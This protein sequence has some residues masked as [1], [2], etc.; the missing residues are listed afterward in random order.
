MY[1]YRPE[2]GLGRS[3]AAGA[4]ARKAVRPEH[5]LADGHHQARGGA[6]NCV[7]T[8]V[9]GGCCPGAARAPTAGAEDLRAADA[10]CRRG[11]ENVQ[12][13]HQPKAVSVAGWA[14][15][16]RAR[17]ASLPLAVLLRCSLHGGPPARGRGKPSEAFAALSGKAWGAC[18]APNRRSFARRLRGLWEWPRPSVKAARVLEQV[19]KLY[20]R[21]KESGLACRRP[22][23]RRASNML[24]RLRRP[25]NRPVQGGHHRHGS[26]QACEQHGRAWALRR[27]CRTPFGPGTRR[28][29]G[30][31]G[32]GGAR[33][34]G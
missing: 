34:G 3:R 26:E 33:R 4:T 23:G 27:R 20:G 21:A 16:R 19:K 30:P 25:M 1:W 32:A 9:G 28:P 10:A 5:R 29:W 11:A 6:S 31:T 14:A 2:V 18:H 15:T 13:G 12:P 22:E 17:L 8:T 24:A 7:A